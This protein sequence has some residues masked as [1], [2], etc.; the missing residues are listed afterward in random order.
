MV[1]E[2]PRVPE[3]WQSAQGQSVPKVRPRGVA[4]GKRVNIPVPRREGY[5]PEEGHRSK[6]AVGLWLCRCKVVGVSGG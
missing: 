3:P 4:D 6:L 2:S 5:Y 1:I